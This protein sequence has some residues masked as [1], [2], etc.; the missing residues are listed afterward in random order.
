MFPPGSFDGVVMADVLEHLLDLPRAIQQARAHVHYTCTAGAGGACAAHVH[1]MH[2]HVHVHVHVHCTTTL[3]LSCTLTLD[4][5]P[6]QVRRVLRPGGVLVFDT[7]N[8]SYQ[9]YLLTIVLA[10]ELHALWLY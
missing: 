9:S 6:E 4:P 10:Q 7:I 5:N 3:A 2:V 8:R 1:C